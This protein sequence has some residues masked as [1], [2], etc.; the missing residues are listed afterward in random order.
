MSE[1]RAQFRG[2]HSS[3]DTILNSV[4]S[5]EFSGIEGVRSLRMLLFLALA[6]AGC[7]NN[8]VPVSNEQAQGSS[9]QAGEVE[10]NFYKRRVPKTGEVLPPPILMRLSGTLTL[11]NGCLI[12]A[13]ADGNHALVFEEGLASFIPTDGRLKAGSTE[14]AIGNPISVGGP[15][16]QPSDDFDAPS[17]KRRCDVSSVWLVTG[18]DVQSLP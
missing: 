10:I 3:G 7:S 14:I 5:R 8:R 11:R 12:L 18:Q 4:V 15:Y 9:A 13:N 17:I 1:F 16:N 2:H 6:C